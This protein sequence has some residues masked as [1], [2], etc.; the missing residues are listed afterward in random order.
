[1]PGGRPSTYTLEQAQHL[2]RLMVS[3]KEDGAPYSFRDACREAGIAES[4]VYQWK[5]AQAEF[6]E[7]YARARLD[8]ADMLAEDVLRVVDDDPDPSSARVKMDARKWYAGKLNPRQWGDKTVLA[9]DPDAPQ[10]HEH[11]HKGS[12]HLDALTSSL[13]RLATRGGEGGETG[14]DQ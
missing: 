8:R 3:R 1:M 2:C 14:K 6:A 12:I 9:G 11:E 10:K 13:T 4:T 7:M 5:D